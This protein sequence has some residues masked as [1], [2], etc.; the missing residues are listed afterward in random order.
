MR[1][2]R[3]MVLAAIFA[4]SMVPL[5]FRVFGVPKDG[6]AWAGATERLWCCVGCRTF[7]V[8]RGNG[9]MA[10]WRRAS[11][12]CGMGQRNMEPSL[13]RNGNR[14]EWMA[15]RLQS[16]SQTHSIFSERVG[17]EGVFAFTELHSLNSERIHV[18]QNARHSHIPSYHQNHA[19]P[20][21]TPPPHINAVPT[22]PFS[23]T[24]DD[25]QP[26][27]LCIRQ[28]HTYLNRMCKRI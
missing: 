26:D 24:V 16:S 5:A 2:R 1:T 23:Q 17:G 9:G 10:G 3:D 19:T 22:Q 7:S 11:G 25:S 27:L 18:S 6:V 12:F 21:H 15:G 14:T 4:F 13:K 8:N 20:T 28:T